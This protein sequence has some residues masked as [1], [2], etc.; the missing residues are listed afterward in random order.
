MSSHDVRPSQSFTHFVINI[1][2]AP[3]QE[4]YAVEFARTYNFQDSMVDLIEAE[5][6]EE[7]ERVVEEI[8]AL[9][10]G[11]TDKKFKTLD[12]DAVASDLLD[13]LEKET[14]G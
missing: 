13:W 2:L 1:G 4:Q 7:R 6:K 12:Y 14:N 5:R 11:N 8:K 10:S 9:V 3:T